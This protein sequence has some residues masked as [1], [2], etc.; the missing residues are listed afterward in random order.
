MILSSILEAF[1][2]PTLLT[3]CFLKA[4]VAA[5]CMF[6][7]SQFPGL[8]FCVKS[9]RERREMVVDGGGRRQKRSQRREGGFASEL[10]K[11]SYH[12]F[13]TPCYLLTRCGGLRRLPPLPPTS[14]T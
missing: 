5:A 10:C 8:I 6:F 11:D 1:W 9:D 4:P 14:R 12:I 3:F 7:G 2:E 13:S